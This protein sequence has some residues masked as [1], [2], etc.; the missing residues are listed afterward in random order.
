MYAFVCM[1]AFVAFQQTPVW[2]LNAFATFRS[3]RLA[4]LFSFHA[5]GAVLVSTPFAFIIARVYRRFG[6]L[7][8]SVITLVVWGTIEAS[9][10]SDA[11]K[12]GA[13][14]ARGFWIADSVELLG[15]L[16]ALV[17]LAQHLPSNNR[18]KGP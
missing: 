10:M 14:G 3:G 11:F 7:V 2:W 15:F 12:S 9:L 5:A 18:W 16:P 13:F 1:V 17:W 4:W 6:V 8:A